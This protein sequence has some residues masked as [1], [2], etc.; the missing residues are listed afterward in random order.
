MNLHEREPEVASQAAG[1][2]PDPG[3][4]RRE[5]AQALRAAVRR[6]TKSLVVEQRSFDAQ[7]GQ[8]LDAG[9]DPPRS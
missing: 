1:L 2:E 4:E 8:E 6:A 7:R 9:D 5:A 3:A